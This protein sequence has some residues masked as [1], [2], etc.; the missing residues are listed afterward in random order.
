MVD[1]GLGGPPA[2]EIVAPEVSKVVVI[3]PTEA[4]T[5]EPKPEE[6]NG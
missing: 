4:A 2:K 6:V 5:K 1:Y 3:E